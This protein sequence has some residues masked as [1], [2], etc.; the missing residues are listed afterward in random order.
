MIVSLITFL[1]TSI[2]F[3]CREESQIVPQVI[4]AIINLPEGTHVAVKHTSI[5]MLGELSEWIEKHPEVIGRS[6]YRPG[7]HPRSSE[8]YQYTYA[9]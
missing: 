8:T 5:H 1:D 6:R 3:P 7:R 2:R 9:R 4:Q